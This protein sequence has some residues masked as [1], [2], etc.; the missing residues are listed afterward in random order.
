MFKFF[1]KNDNLNNK[2]TIIENPIF[3]KLKYVYTWWSFDRIDINMFGKTYSVMYFVASNA[4]KEAPNEVQ[5]RAFKKFLAEKE[6]LQ[7]DAEKI[8]LEEI[9]L[10]ESYEISDVINVVEVCISIDGKCG[11][12]MEIKEE[13]LDDIDLD[14]LDITPDNS[15]GV[16]LFPELKII[17]SSDTFDEIFK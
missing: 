11:I 9:K 3:G 4:Q 16:S 10:D 12:A 2:E 1:K 6:Q 5:Q 7:R 8:I 17:K 13:Y 15:F 14:E